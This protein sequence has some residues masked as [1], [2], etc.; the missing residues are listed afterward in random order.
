V[1]RISFSKHIKCILKRV[2]Q[3]RFFL[4]NVF[5]LFFCSG[6]GTAVAAVVVDAI[7]E[8]QRG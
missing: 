1:F 6:D 4:K 3:K 8:K 2:F 7:R 5:L